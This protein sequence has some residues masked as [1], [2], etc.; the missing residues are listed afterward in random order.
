MVDLSAAIAAAREA[1]S[2]L[3]EAVNASL[4]NKDASKADAFRLA[5]EDA[6]HDCTH[7]QR[8]LLAALDQHPCCG[9]DAG[10]SR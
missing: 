5:V 7:T 8:D 9:K 1:Q 6:K 2:R 10:A 4:A 3:D